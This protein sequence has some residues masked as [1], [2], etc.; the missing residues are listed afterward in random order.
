MSEPPGVPLSE[1]FDEFAPEVLKSALA[2]ARRVRRE[3]VSELE[4]R[5][6]RWKDKTLV[7][8]SRLAGGKA[9][10]GVDRLSRAEA[11]VQSAKHAIITDLVAQLSRG[12]GL[13][14][15]VRGNPI[16][17]DYKLVNAD[18]WPPVRV[19]WKG[20]AYFP[21]Q[22]RTFYDVRIARRVVEEEARDPPLADLKD[23]SQTLVNA[24]IKQVYDTCEEAGEKAPNKNELP[25]KVHAI[26]KA[27]GYKTS[28]NAIKK[29]ADQP[30]HKKRRGAIGVRW[31]RNKRQ[32][33]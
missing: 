6:A 5:D 9:L 18:A 4:V 30:Q 15:Y 24:A 14:G 25:P 23:A 8:L 7:M 28:G 19:N 20:T 17:G 22:K 26:L 10:P 12:G 32:P 31:R 29:L 1:A 2:E 16:T 27:K 33:K 21:G 11:D 3:V 13:D